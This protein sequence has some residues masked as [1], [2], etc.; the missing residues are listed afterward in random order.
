MA[1]YTNAWQLHRERDARLA[2]YDETHVHNGDGEPLSQK[3]ARAW[4]AAHAASGDSYNEKPTSF[5]SWGATSY[6][7]R[8]GLEAQRSYRVAESQTWGPY[9]HDDHPELT[10]ENEEWDRQREDMTSTFPVS[11]ELKEQWD[12]SRAATHSKVKSAESTYVD[13]WVNWGG[14]TVQV[15]P[16]NTHHWIRDSHDAHGASVLKG[17]QYDEERVRDMLRWEERN[18]P[19]ETKHY[20]PSTTTIDTLDPY[21]HPS[22]DHAFGLMGRPISRTRIGARPAIS[23]LLFRS[24]LGDKSM[25]EIEHEI[26]ADE[27]RAGARIFDRSDQLTRNKWTGTNFQS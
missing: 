11:D 12:A 20:L 8:K 27:R 6:P 1:E 18:K 13:Q 14:V 9:E 24:K 25:W 3:E 15:D 7:V 10:R 5:S 22:N 2:Q 21:S 16:V 17:R 4:R 23:E 26:L 19:P